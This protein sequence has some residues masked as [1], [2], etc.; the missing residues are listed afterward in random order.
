[1]NLNFNNFDIDLKHLH[2]IRSGLNIEKDHILEMACLITDK[3]LV[4]KLNIF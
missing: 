1:M 4:G 3:N 2:A